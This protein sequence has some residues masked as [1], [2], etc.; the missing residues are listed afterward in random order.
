MNNECHVLHKLTEALRLYPPNARYL[1]E[2]SGG[3]DSVA[4]LHGLLGQGFQR[5]EPVELKGW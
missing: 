4:L 1:V 2:V 3:R 5:L